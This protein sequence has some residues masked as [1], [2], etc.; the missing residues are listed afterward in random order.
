MKINVQSVQLSNPGS[1][2]R[3]VKR[4]AMATFRLLRAGAAQ[5]SKVPGALAQ[6]TADVRSAWQESASPKA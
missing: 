2:E 3:L 5:A 4:G 6:A 1:S